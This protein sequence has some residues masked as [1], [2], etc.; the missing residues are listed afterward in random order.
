VDFKRI[1]IG[2][3]VKKEVR[4]Y[5]LPSEVSFNSPKES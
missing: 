5:P 1:K 3:F 2:G 4:I